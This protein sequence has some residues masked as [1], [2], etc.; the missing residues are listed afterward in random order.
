MEHE[1]LYGFLLN[2]YED[3]LRDSSNN[4]ASHLEKSTRIPYLS[5]AEKAG[6][7]RVVRRRGHETMPRFIGRWFPR[8]DLLVEHE[9]YAAWMLMLLSP[10]RNLTDL[11]PPNNTFHDTFL[12]FKTTLTVHELN[13]LENFQYYH[14]CWDLANER[15]EAAKRGEIIPMFNYDREDHVADVPDT[16]SLEDVEHSSDDT[17]FW[18]PQQVTEEMIDDARQNQTTGRDRK[19][20]ADAM[21]AAFKGNVFEASHHSPLLSAMTIGARAD[22]EDLKLFARWEKILQEITRK[23]LT[24]RGIVDLSTI[25]PGENPRAR[26]AQVVEPSLRQVSTEDTLLSS[27][28]VPR[29]SSP[30]EVRPRP[31]LDMLNEDQRRAHDIVENKVFG[32]PPSQLN[33]QKLFIKLT[34]SSQMVNF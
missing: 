20:A 11:K 30:Q 34:T 14:Q 15:K 5:T 22:A 8:N 18:I 31:R 16:E 28:S 12:T 25:C 3:A 10:W 23:E 21:Q 9:F 29:D 24:E 26:V 2:T 33:N 13:L 4:E 27:E 7:C 6:R 19:F 17:M 1:S 32:D